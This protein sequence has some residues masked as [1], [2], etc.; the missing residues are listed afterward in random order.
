MTMHSHSD[1]SQGPDSSISKRARLWLFVAALGGAV[2][3]AT[4]TL[5][6]RPY[7]PNRLPETIV[8][9]V[10]GKDIPLDIYG[11]AVNAL[12]ADKRNELTNQDRLYLLKRI[13]DEELL[14][15]RG[16]KM[17]FVESDPTVRKAI[18]AAMIESIVTEASTVKPTTVELEDFYEENKAFFMQPGRLW[19]RQIYFSSSAAAN[20][21]GRAQQAVEAI[22]SGMSFEE[23]KTK[24]GD[25]PILKIP[26]GL[27]PPQKLREYIGPTL[28]E[29]ATAMQP[30][31][32]SN[33][34]ASGDSYRVLQLVDLQKEEARDLEVIRPQV[35]VEFR[36][37]AGDQ[38]LR[39]YLDNLHNDADIAY[40]P[41]VET[42]K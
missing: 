41:W 13:I 22:R 10:N 8:A 26:D 5:D 42:L 4:G 9:R 39:S 27:L 14:I 23:A 6:R 16:I 19:V 37:R 1:P 20:P 31:D 40:A 38:A 18:S 29:V 28:T 24:F 2:V 12:A 21:Y 30:G 25:E 34:L 11:T 7:D 32:I 3:A 15:Q 33:P 35:E 17:G 36:R